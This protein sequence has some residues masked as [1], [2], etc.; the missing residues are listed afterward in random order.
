MGNGNSIGTTQITIIELDGNRQVQYNSAQSTII[1][2]GD[3]VVFA[4][5]LSKI[6]LFKA[7][8]YRNDTNHV[9][10]KTGMR[11]EAMIM[12]LL[13]MIAGPLVIWLSL[14]TPADTLFAWVL[15]AISFFGLGLV[16]YGVN[17]W[18]KLSSFTRQAR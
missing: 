6:G 1:N 10:D 17:V 12:G 15:I 8:A 9:S 2:E 11:W 13:I 4:G 18:L 14:I 7:R 5:R 3:H 16:M